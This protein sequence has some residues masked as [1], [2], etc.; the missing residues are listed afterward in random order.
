M[1]KLYIAAGIIGGS[2]G[3]LYLT[4]KVTAAPPVIG[5]RVILAIGDS[6]TASP[7][8]CENLSLMAPKGSSVTCR[9][10]P[11]KGTNSIYVDLKAEY[12]GTSLSK[13][14]DV[15]VLAGVNDIASGR[16]LESIQH[17]LSSIYG[18]V[19][20][21]GPRVVAVHLTPW[22]SYK[23]RKDWLEQTDHINNWISH[24]P[25]PDAVVKTHDMGDFQGSLLPHLTS[26][27]GLHLN[28][29]GTQKLADLV[30]KQGF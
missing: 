18:Y 14:T 29:A 22:Y 23:Y 21:S 16:S 28:K 15:V 17:N 12:P 10:L 8:Y 19:K 24:N 9:G 20:L 6:L 3:L 26:G 4:K 27:D 30:I 1:N 5:P 11:G 13:F 25:V 7:S 2:I